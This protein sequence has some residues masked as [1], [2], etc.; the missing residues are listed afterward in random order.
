[1][2]KF[3]RPHGNNWRGGTSLHTSGYPLVWAPTHP[4][5]SSGYVLEHIILAEKALGRH[6]PDGVEVHHANLI[7]GQNRGGNLV[8]CQ[9]ASYHRLVHRRTAAFR[10]CGHADWR[11]CKHC[12]QYG[13]VDSLLG[14]KITGGGWFHKLC[15]NEYNQLYQKNKR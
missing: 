14:G 15:R 9:D 1:M 12:R 5:A 3:T 4:R 7:R 13:S 6:L 8:I 11:K 2:R 10:A